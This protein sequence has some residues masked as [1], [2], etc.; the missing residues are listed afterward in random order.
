MSNPSKHGTRMSVY[1]SDETLAYI[2]SVAKKD[3]KS[4]SRI[5]DEAVAAYRKERGEVEARSFSVV[6]FL[7]KPGVRSHGDNTIGHSWDNGGRWLL[8]VLVRQEPTWQEHHLVMF[9]RHWPLPLDA[10][11]LRCYENGGDK[12]CVYDRLRRFINPE[13]A[14][15]SSFPPDLPLPT[16]EEWE[17]VCRRY[18]GCCGE[19]IRPPDGAHW[20]SVCSASETGEHLLVRELPPD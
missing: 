7:L 11:E 2:E 14:D 16:L 13:Y 9:P 19:V 18:K 15:M 4:V 12:R 20:D 3:E 5:V 8:D 17:E 6:E 10:W 1:T